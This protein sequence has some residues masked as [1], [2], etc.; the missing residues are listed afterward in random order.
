MDCP[1]V[2][3]ASTWAAQ[4]GVWAPWRVPQAF[5]MEREALESTGTWPCFQMHLHTELSPRPCMMLSSP[6]AETGPSSLYSRFFISRPLKP[7]KR[8]CP[9][10]LC[11]WAQPPSPPEH[12]GTGVGWFLPGF[13][14]SQVRLDV[15][16]Q[17]GILCLTATVASAS[18]RG[19]LPSCYPAVR[20]MAP[21]MCEALLRHIK[22]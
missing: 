22:E 13:L 12:A 8:L 21:C 4:L 14:T 9:G 18:T 6:Q 20:P 15:R 3:P 10:L 19:P 1:Q 7:S 5:P 17:N 11:S 16:P 2:L